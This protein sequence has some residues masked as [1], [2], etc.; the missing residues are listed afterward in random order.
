VTRRSDPTITLDARKAD[1]RRR[2]IGVGLV[3]DQAD[4]WITALLREGGDCSR[5]AFWATGYDWICDSTGQPPA[6]LGSR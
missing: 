2:L 1:L 6:R 3:S 4:R 5:A